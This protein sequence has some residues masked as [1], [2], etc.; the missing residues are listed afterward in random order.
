MTASGEHGHSGYVVA[1]VGATGLI[2]QTLLTVLAERNTPIRELRA[3]ATEGQGRRVRFRGD[4]I[5]V[6]AVGPDT[7]A[8]ADVVFMAATKEAS[9]RWGPWAAE[10]GSLVVDKSSRFR[11]DPDVPLVVPE[12]N[13]HAIGSKRLIA[14]PNCSTIQLVMALKPIAD[15]REIRR[16]LVSTYQAVSGTGRDAVEELEREARADATGDAAPTPAVYPYPIAFNVIPQ[17][18]AFGDLGF[19]GE[20][21]KLVRESQKILERPLRLSAT[22]V[23]VP[24]RVGHSESVYVELDRPADPEEVRAWLA[25]M[26]GV[27][28]VDDPAR[29][30]YP[31]PLMAAGRDTVLVGRI[32]RD[33][34]VPEGLHLFVVSDNL[35]KGAA[36]NAVQIMEAVMGR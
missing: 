27:E 30:L 10:R 22:C 13:A 2:G 9:E 33:P 5:P 1:I 6:Q 11:M 23:R 14:S 15:H 24:V 34:H 19:D 16:V 7:L 12:V 21:W 18:D 29:R 25:A 35:R 26:P 8:G 31:T 3:L 28:V 17:C 20:E 36:T 4:E 32:R